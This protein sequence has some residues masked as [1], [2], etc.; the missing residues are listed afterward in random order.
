MTGHHE[1]DKNVKQLQKD[2]SKTEQ[3]SLCMAQQ[4]QQNV[5]SI[6]ELVR[7]DK[8]RPAESKKDSPNTLAVLNREFVKFCIL[9]FLVWIDLASAAAVPHSN[10]L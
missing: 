10:L 7:F 8:D 5:S 4:H 9:Q 1:T 6:S 3:T 2:P